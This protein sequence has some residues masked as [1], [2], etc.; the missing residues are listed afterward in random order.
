MRK[1]KSIT[2]VCGGTKATFHLTDFPELIQVSSSVN[3]FHCRCSCGTSLIQIPFHADMGIFFKLMQARW[4]SKCPVELY[5]H[6]CS[7]LV[8][9]EIIAFC[10]S[11]KNLERKKKKGRKNVAMLLG[12]NGESLL[13]LEA[14]RLQHLYNQICEH[15]GQF[16]LVIFSTRAN[17]PKFT[18]HPSPEK[19]SYLPKAF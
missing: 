10:G 6:S 7:P 14:S 15:K 3:H 8:L 1:K 2:C 13:S 17:K 11:G 19:S 18:K 12:E 16:G 9:C 5:W 4:A